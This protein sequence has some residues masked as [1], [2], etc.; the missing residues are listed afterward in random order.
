MLHHMGTRNINLNLEQISNIA[1]KIKELGFGKLVLVRSKQKIN[2][3]LWTVQLWTV[4]DL[5]LD[6]P[7]YSEDPV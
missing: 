2:F 5:S 7:E 3:R 6:Y 4:P 1:S